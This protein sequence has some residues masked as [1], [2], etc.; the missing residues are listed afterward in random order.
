MARR[1]KVA[2][3]VRSSVSKLAGLT[4]TV[5]EDVV[6]YMSFPPQHRTN[7]ASTNP[8]V[9]AILLEQDD[10]DRAA[11]PRPRWKASPSRAM[12]LPLRNQRWPPDQPGL[13]E[14]AVV[15]PAKL[16]P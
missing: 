10:V 5:E 14:I 16:H 15:H 9:G 4:A 11:R 12:I 3:Q 6:A 7:L 8:L 13:P 1:R 2:E